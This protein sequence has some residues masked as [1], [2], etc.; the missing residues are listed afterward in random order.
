MKN[1]YTFIFYF[2]I[3]FS[4]SAAE[5]DTTHVRFHNKTNLT[6]YG[7]YDFKGAFPTAGKSWNKILMKY[8]MGCASTGCSGWDY[9]TH[10]QY[11]KPTGVLDSNIAKID[12][13]MSDTTW[14]VYEVIE[15]IELARVITPYGTYMRDGS[16]GFNNN[17]QQANWYDLTD[18]ASILH[19]SA[20]IRDFYSGWS[21]GYSVTLDFYFIEGNPPRPVLSMDNL[22]G[23]GGNSFGYANSADFETKYMNAKSV[24]K[25]PATKSAKLTFVPSGHGFDN[26]VGAAE[27]FDE[28]FHIKVNGTEVASDHIWNDKCGQNPLFPQ[29]GTWIYNRANWCPGSKVG[30]FSY[31]IG[32]AL[33]ADTNKL[34]IDLD[35]FTWTLDWS[36]VKASPD[37]EVSISNPNGKTDEVAYNNSKASK[38]LITPKLENKLIVWFKS[39]LNSTENSYTFKDGDGKVLFT[40]SGFAPSTLYKDTVSLP[41]GCIN[42]ELYDDGGDGIDWWANKQT[43]GSGYCWLKNLAGNFTRKINPDFGD[44][45]IFRFNTTYG[46]SINELA[47]TPSNYDI[48]PNPAG[49]ILNIQSFTPEL[50]STAYLYD[51]SGKKVGEYR[52]NSQTTIDISAFNQGI[53][54]VKIE[55]KNGAYFKKLLIER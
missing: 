9:T 43:V 10:I 51:V 23:K 40:K 4:V 5:G 35:P 34:D 52:F 12:T 31:E 16:L 54:I 27:F 33:K 25:N 47:E 38:A 14:Y 13:L 44:R 18:F 15:N 41:D 46:L 28:P 29:G 36:N 26:S 22:W 11:L 20:T 30:I 50:S 6:S 7:N 24:Y 37:F 8:T 17:W 2:L 3:V 49:L 21:S 45:I 19:D 32:N 1:I 42:F 53:Y 48:Y 39:N 55:D